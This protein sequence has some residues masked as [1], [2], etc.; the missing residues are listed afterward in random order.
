MHSGIRGGR[1][2]RYQCPKET[3]WDPAELEI[4]DYEISLLNWS[5]GPEI[6]PR[7]A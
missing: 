2:I 4:I 3:S 5:K 7:E 6:P 1:Y